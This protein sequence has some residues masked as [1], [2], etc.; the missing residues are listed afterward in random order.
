METVIRDIKYGVRGLLKRP[1]FTLI[2]VITLALGIGANAAIF[3]VVNA[4]LLKR[5]QFREPDRLVV[6][7]EEA[8]FAGFPTNTPA[9]GN[10]VD[11][12]TQAQ[13]FEDMAAFSDQ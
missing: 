1:A 11:W 7:W 12:K 2:A 8:T 5:M 6:V 3:S 9:P 10:F 4:V 13:S